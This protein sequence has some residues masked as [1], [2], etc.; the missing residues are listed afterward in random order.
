VE[1]LVSADFR[2]YTI[3]SLLMLHQVLVGFILIHRVFANHEI[4]SSFNF[5]H[6]VVGTLAFPQLKAELRKGN[7]LSC[8][9][10][11]EVHDSV[12]AQA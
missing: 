11:I 6:K 7:F 3:Y 4:Y 1:K 12:G 10:D 2:E 8:P 9:V 5:E